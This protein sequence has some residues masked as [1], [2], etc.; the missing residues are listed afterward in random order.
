MTAAVPNPSF[1]GPGNRGPQWGSACLKP[2]S[3]SV[4]GL[5][6]SPKL[7]ALW[8]TPQCC[9]SIPSR[10]KGR[11]KMVSI[12][13]SKGKTRFTALHSNWS[14]FSNLFISFSS[15]LTFCSS[16]TDLRP[17]PVL[18]E[19]GLVLFM[20]THTPSRSRNVGPRLPQVNW[21]GGEAWPW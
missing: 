21:A 1:P 7:R 2:Q 20:Y 18:Y 19:P 15:P 6:F 3:Q 12:P 5:R 4:E 11:L 10:P 16:R 8:T 13:N 9:P 14:S 17:L